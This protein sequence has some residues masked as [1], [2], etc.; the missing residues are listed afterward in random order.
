MRK[1]ESHILTSDVLC[2]GDLVYLRLGLFTTEYGYVPLQTGTNL[3]FK[4]ILVKTG[5]DD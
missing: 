4:L 5:V 2:S 3:F 1:G